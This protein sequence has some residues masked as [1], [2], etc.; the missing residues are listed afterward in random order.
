M[1]RFEING[2]QKLF[3]EI[4]LD[5]AKNS[6]LPILAACVLINGTAVIHNCPKLT[7]ILYTFRIL[8]GLG[9]KVEYDGK[10][11]TVNAENISSD[12]TDI[13][14]ADKMRSSVLFLGALL[15]RLHSAK[16]NLPGGCRI[17]ERPIDLHINALSD[18]GAEFFQSDERIIATA[19]RLLGEEIKLPFPS[20][21]ATENIILASVLVG[22]TTT[23][24]NAAREPEI[25]DLADFLNKAGAR[26]RGA[27]EYVIRIDGVKSLHGTEHTVIPDRIVASTYMSAC[28]AC[29][30]S[31]VMKNVRLSHLVPI[32]SVFNKLGCSMTVGGDVLMVSK[33]T[34]PRTI[35]T[36]ETK[37]Y[38]GFPTDSQPMLCA[39]LCR[40]R[41]T[42]VIKETV[43]EKRFLFA[44]ELE[45]FG[46][47]I[48]AENSTL[49]IQGTRHLKGADVTA[50]DLRGGA[51]LVIAALSAKGKS[52]VNNIEYIDRG[53]ER[54]DEKL[55]LLGADIKRIY[56]EEG[57]E[58]DHNS[59][60]AVG[61]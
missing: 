3:G 18:L 48:S 50:C 24:I 9:C 19:P 26:I 56:Y 41:G 16:V 54:F 47:N 25:A 2:G 5:G 30:G 49:K 58:K 11:A 55:A 52:T 15:G 32:V 4:T 17:G 28:A 59:K 27:G 44:K 40:S 22:G 7:D 51:A 57:K 61:R 20:V 35:G 29:G 60:E 14:Y 38:P 39:A 43:F 23:I 37:P 45:K 34:P 53:Y 8:E 10:T 13:R 21:G 1:E 33:K 36:L 31:V 6:A 12:A 42:S 46:A